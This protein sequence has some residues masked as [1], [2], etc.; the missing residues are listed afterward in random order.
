[1]LHDFFHIPSTPLSRTLLNVIGLSTLPSFTF[2]RET[3]GADTAVI[4][5]EL[6]FILCHGSEDGTCW[7]QPVTWVVG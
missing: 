7:R 6:N 1:M 5:V 3:L 2:V 4:F